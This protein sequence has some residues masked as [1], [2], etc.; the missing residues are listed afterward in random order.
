[1][2]WCTWWKRHSQGTRCSR[3]CTLHWMRSSTISA[4]RNCISGGQPDTRPRCSACWA[5]LSPE[6]LG[7]PSGD[8]GTLQRP[9]STPREVP[10][11]RNVGQVQQPGA[12]QHGLRVPGAQA[13]QRHEQGA[14][15]QQPVDV[16]HG[17]RRRRVPRRARQGTRRAPAAGR[18]PRA[19]TPAR[20]RP[21]RRAHRGAWHTSQNQRRV[22]HVRRSTVNGEL[23]H[24][25]HPDGRGCSTSHSRRRRRSY[26]CSAGKMMLPGTSAAAEIRVRGDCCYGS[27]P[28]NITREK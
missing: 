26:K 25:Q 12:A 4:T 8:P 17:I 9:S 20:C 13:L 21:G 14:E 3:L 7:G 23:L 18:E 27:A 28:E 10:V 19:P 1:M 11:E 5:W 16:L 15:D 6:T 2:L 22:A 24:M